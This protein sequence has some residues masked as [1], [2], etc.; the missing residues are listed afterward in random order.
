MRNDINNRAKFEYSLIENAKRKML[1]FL[2]PAYHKII[3]FFSSEF[4]KL[5]EFS[6]TKNLLHYLDTILFFSVMTDKYFV[7]D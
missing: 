7:T 2:L 3:A 4:H 5:T 6:L 1:P